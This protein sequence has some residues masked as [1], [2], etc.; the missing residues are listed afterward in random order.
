MWICYYFHQL[1]IN[2]HQVSCFKLCFHIFKRSFPSFLHFS[3]TLQFIIKTTS[4]FFQ[5]FQIFELALFCD[6]T[7][8]TRFFE[9]FQNFICGSILPQFGKLGLRGCELSM[10]AIPVGMLQNQLSLSQKILKGKLN[11]DLS[12]A[13]CKSQWTSGHRAS[14]VVDIHLRL[15]YS[16]SSQNLKCLP[17]DVSNTSDVEHSVHRI[18]CT[19]A[20]MTL[21]DLRAK[22]TWTNAINE[23]DMSSYVQSGFLT[24][25]MQTDAHDKGEEHSASYLGFCQMAGSSH[26]R[27]LDIKIYPR[28]WDVAYQ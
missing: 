10:N 9:L 20:C 16:T 13:R 1:Q 21:I 3:N 7:E 18:L 14:F 28:M 22:I 26:V 27:R 24:D 8:T 6:W 17:A 5:L 25:D 12:K 11:S 4:T 15:Y 2:A 23:P 19:L